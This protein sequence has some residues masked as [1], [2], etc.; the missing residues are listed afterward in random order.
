MDSILTSI[1]KALGITEEYEHF[2]ADIIMHIN[3]ILSVLTQLGVGKDSGF[4]IKDKSA[5]WTDFMP[6]DSRLEMVKSYVHLRVKQLFDPPLSNAVAE[7]M[8]RSIAELEWRI[9]VTVDPPENSIE[10]EEIQNE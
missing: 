9:N 2:D 5:V 3:T 6:S 4:S 8:N 10:Q 7:A 1:K